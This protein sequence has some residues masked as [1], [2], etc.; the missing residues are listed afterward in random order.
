MVTE[1][2]VTA[3]LDSRQLL[4][5]LLAVKKGD[6]SVRMPEDLTGM[7]GKVADALNEII[8]LNERLARELERV[9]T[10]V[11]KE[12]K[13]TQRASLGD[14]GGSWAGCVESVNILI[15]GLVQPTTEV[16]R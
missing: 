13:I 6:F 12:G 10:A 14:A 1:T 9:G 5:V 4:R 2:T 15:G 7:A 8:E 3:T 16:A 11:G